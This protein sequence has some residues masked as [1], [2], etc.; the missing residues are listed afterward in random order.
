MIDKYYGIIVYVHIVSAI[1]WVG[2]VLFLG[3]IAI[4]AARKLEEAERR[5]VVSLLG[6]AFRP[7]GWTALSLLILTGSLMMIRWGA[8]WSNLADLTF[9]HSPHTRILGYKLITV[10]LM[11]VISGVHD[12]YLGPKASEMPLDHP[13]RGKVRTLSSWLGRVTGILVLIIVAFAIVL[14]RPWL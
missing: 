1:V 12:W 5:E 7:V 2:G 3:V 4:P 9:F 6:R 10:T 14:A 13:K 8:T 11:L